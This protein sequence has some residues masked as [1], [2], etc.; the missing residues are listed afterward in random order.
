MSQ[1]KSNAKL[2]EQEKELQAVKEQVLELQ[3]SQQLMLHN[4]ELAIFP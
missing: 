4:A 1:I 3:R 2:K